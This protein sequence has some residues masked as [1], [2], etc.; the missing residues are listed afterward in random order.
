MIMKEK[1]S[2]MT[3]KISLQ[4]VHSIFESRF[5]GKQVRIYEAGGGSASSIPTD[6]LSNA[7]VTVVDIDELQLGRNKYAEIKILGDI[8]T[9][10]FPDDSFDLIVCYNVIEHLPAPDRAI[11]LF[12][13]A[14]APGGLLFIAAPNPQ[15]FSGWVTKVTPHWFHVQYYRRIL[16]YKGAGRPGTV[17]FPTFFHRVVN[18]SALMD[19][20]LKLG[21]KVIYFCE[22]RAMV[23]EYMGHRRPS[24][25]KL[26]D[27]LVRAI[28]VVTLWRKD[29]RNGDYHIVLEKP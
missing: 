6:I 7:Q 22:Y 19:F 24:L 12:F 26:L 16:G 14:L 28:N 8:Q 11:E 4:G 23:Y 3:G 10:V 21:F 18:P 17:P 13:Q 29:L 27:L 2:H 5:S 1:M 9:H 15:S 20:C 25:T